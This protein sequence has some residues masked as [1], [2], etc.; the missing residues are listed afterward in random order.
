MRSFTLPS[1]NKW[2]LIA[3]IGGRHGF[4]EY[5]YDHTT[6]Y[7]P[8]ITKGEIHFI[9]SKKYIIQNHQTMGYSAWNQPQFAL[10]SFG[11][12]SELW[13]KAA[14]GVSNGPFQV[15][16][17]KHVTLNLGSVSDLDLTDNGGNLKIYDKL[18]DNS[19]IYT[20]NLNV[21][22]GTSVLVQQHQRKGYP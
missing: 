8:S 10:V 22:D 18:A 5:I 6:S 21:I 15:L 13:F 11:S 17:S 9:N 19:H 2:H 3:T 12:T 20:G 1:D 16:T 7:H 14:S 4:I